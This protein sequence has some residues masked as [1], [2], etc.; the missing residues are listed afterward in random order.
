M[1]T[2]DVLNP[3]KYKYNGAIYDSIEELERRERE[4]IDKMLVRWVQ[5][6]THEE[7]MNRDPYLLS[8]MGSGHYSSHVVS[9]ILTER[10]GELEAKIEER[11]KAYEE[12][13]NALRAFKYQEKTDA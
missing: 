7:R 13:D 9:K 11:R 2:I 10:V 4:H 5:Q 8:F 3:I 6:E 1:K 12:L